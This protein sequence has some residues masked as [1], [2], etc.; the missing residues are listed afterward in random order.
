VNNNIQNNGSF[1]PPADARHAKRGNQRSQKAEKRNQHN[2]MFTKT[3]NNFGIDKNGK[4]NVRDIRSQEGPSQ[5]RSVFS[6]V[7]LTTKFVFNKKHKH[8]F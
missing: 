5:L 3:V 6:E 2:P 7:K 4:T 8:I 1:L